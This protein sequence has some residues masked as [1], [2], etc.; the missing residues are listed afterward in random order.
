MVFSVAISGVTADK[1]NMGWTATTILENHGW[2]GGRAA[3]WKG[4]GVGT[5]W[6]V[7]RALRLLTFEKIRS[8][9]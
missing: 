6:R 9:P 5:I 8:D 4:M 2:L 3:Y 7:V 1:M